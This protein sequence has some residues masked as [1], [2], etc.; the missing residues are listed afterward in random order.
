MLISKFL[1]LGDGQVWLGLGMFAE[2]ARGVALEETLIIG[3]PL[4]TSRKSSRNY[5]DISQLKQ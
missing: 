1:R 4:L 5:E 2:G 3:K